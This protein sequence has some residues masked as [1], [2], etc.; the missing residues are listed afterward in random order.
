MHY[1]IV[2]IAHTTAFV[3]PVV[4][5]WLVREIAQSVHN[6]GSIRRS[7]RTFLPRNYISLMDCKG[8]DVLLKNILSQVLSL[9]RIN[10]K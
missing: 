10:G 6:E 9:L 3:T 1:P 7:E 4:G 5:H 8:V 2:K